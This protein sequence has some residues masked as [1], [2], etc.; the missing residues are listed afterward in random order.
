MANQYA[1]RYA[2]ARAHTH[3]HTHTHTHSHTPTHNSHYRKDCHA[4]S[5]V[6]SNCC[7]HESPVCFRVRT[8]NLA[9]YITK[10]Y[11]PGVQL[12]NLKLHLH[13][14]NYVHITVVMEQC[15]KK[16]STNSSS[17]G[18]SSYSVKTNMATT[19]VVHTNHNT[20]PPLLP[21]YKPITIIRSSS[22][23]QY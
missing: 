6:C 1:F 18:P 14:C 21:S 23:Y 13:T 4:P 10:C 16:T 20:L 17:V 19:L 3:T 5:G 22:P 11:V 2:R 8:A 7:A 9:N 15:K 12:S